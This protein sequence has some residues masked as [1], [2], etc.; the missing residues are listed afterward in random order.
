[1]SWIG[2]AAIA[3]LSFCIGFSI[4]IIGDWGRKK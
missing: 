2:V 4:G 3:F 1:M